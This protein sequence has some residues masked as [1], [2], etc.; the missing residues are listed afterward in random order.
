MI[1][2]LL[3]SIFFLQI[4]A[5]PV[6][7]DEQTTLASSVLDDLEEDEVEK[8]IEDVY[9]RIQ[10]FEN[11]ILR[12]MPEGQSKSNIAY[13]WF[14]KYNIFFEMENANISLG[15]VGIRFQNGTLLSP[16]FALWTEDRL[17]G[18]AV[19]SHMMQPAR[20]PKLVCEIEWLEE[21]H[22]PRKGVD[23]I[24][25]H[26]LSAPYSG[27][28]DDHGVSTAVEEAWLL[29]SRRAGSLP[30]PDNMRKRSPTPSFL[31]KI[32]IP[33][34]NYVCDM[35]VR[36]VLWSAVS[37]QETLLPLHQHRW[38]VIIA[39]IWI[40]REFVRLWSWLLFPLLRPCLG[41]PNDPQRP[42]LVIFQRTRT[43]EPRQEYYY[44][45]ELNHLF[46]PPRFS[47][48]GYAPPVSTNLHMCHFYKNR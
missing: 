43:A 20:V 27:L 5:L 42:Y 33:G 38:T 26:Y 17:D 19:S 22:Q 16:D 35:L 28:P 1:P 13:D 21:V 48:L 40:L 18:F 11:Q 9:G 36:W 3:F 41:P 45:F 29:V 24:V 6:H 4:P 10:I 23:K 39:I 25:N 12:D 34:I 44:H 32:P 37:L 46:I 14:S 2:C 30:V 31:A 15:T 8:V 47:I 7:E